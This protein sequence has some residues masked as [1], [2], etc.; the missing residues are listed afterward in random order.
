MERTNGEYTRHINRIMSTTSTTSKKLQKKLR[1]TSLLSLLRGK[2]NMKLPV[3]L[4][5]IFAFLIQAISYKQITKFKL[6]VVARL[7]K[8]TRKRRKRKMRGKR[9]R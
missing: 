7:M 1:G 6:E 5:L 2:Y 3:S 8:G 9:R 4:S